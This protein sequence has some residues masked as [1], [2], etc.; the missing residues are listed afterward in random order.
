[1]G[2]EPVCQQ[3]FLTNGDVI[4]QLPMTAA[5]HEHANWT[6]D[7]KNKRVVM[8]WSLSPT[9]TID[10]LHAEVT[11]QAVQDRAKPWQFSSYSGVGGT[12]H[13]TGS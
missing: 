10:R 2:D 7:S 1:M 9:L 4:S 12:H 13:K 6:D 11:L 8:G 5:T 3:I